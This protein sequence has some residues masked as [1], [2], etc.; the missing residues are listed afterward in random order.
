[1]VDFAGFGT[2]VDA[3]GGIDVRVAKATS[4]D[5]AFFGQGAN[6]LDGPRALAYLRQS[7]GLPRGDLDRAQRQQNVLRALL[8]KTVANDLSANPVQLFRLLEAV[9]RSASVDDTIGDGGVRELRN[10]LR[11]LQPTEMTFLA[12]PLRGFGQEDSQSV[13]YL[14]DKRAIDLWNALRSDSAATYA[15]LY[16]DN[17]LGAT[18]P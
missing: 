3:V 2:I 1:M 16:P 17:S 4:S 12:A 15:S 10:E 6:H 7:A 14:D 13:V 18:P 8:E 11:G 9:S 5:G